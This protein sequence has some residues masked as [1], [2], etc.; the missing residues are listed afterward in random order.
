MLKALVVVTT[1]LAPAAAFADKDF[2]GADDGATW[3]CSQDAKVNINYSDATF[4]LTGACE[5]INVNGSNVK[6]TADDVGTTNINGAKNSMKTNILGA[7]NI[8][9]TGNKVTY[10]KAKTGKKPKVASMG[11][12]NS[13]SKVTK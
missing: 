7:A 4:T 8:T 6:I 9:G 10:K 5:E 2:M 13:V 12:G 3:D 1:L 11:K